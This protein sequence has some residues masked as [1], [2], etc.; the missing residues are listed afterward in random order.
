MTNRITLYDTTLRDG[1][2]TRGVNFSVKDKYKIS[3][4]LN[5][6]G[7]AYIEFGWPGANPVDDEFFASPPILN[8]AKLA[9]FGMTCRSKNKAE[10]DSGLL[11]LAE[12]KA[13]SV[14][15]VGKTWDFHAI[16]AL[17]VSLDE[18]TRMIR[19][20]T[21]FIESQGKEVLFDAEHFFD[22]FRANKEY[23]LSCLREAH[24]AGAAWLV[25]CDTNGGTLPYEIGAIVK[26][27]KKTLPDARLGVHCHDD[28]GNAVADSI[29]ALR[30][31]C[32]MVQ[33]TLNGL[34]ER[35]GN[36]NLV[37]LIPTL[38]DK[39]GYDVGVSDAQ[40]ETLTEMSRSF[41]ML[42]DRDV[43]SNA[44]YV[45]ASAFAHKGGLHASAVAKDP[46]MYEHISPELVGN[47]REVI[48]SDQAGVSN[49]RQQLGELGIEVADDNPALKTLLD[50]VKLRGE[51]GFAYD[52][53]LASFALLSLRTLGRLP[54]FFSVRSCGIEGNGLGDPDL[55][56]DMTSYA[57]LNLQIGKRNFS[58]K[59][60]GVG[61]VNALDGALRRAL[62]GTYPEIEEIRLVDYHV[63]ILDTKAATAATTRVLLESENIKDNSSWVTIGISTNIINASFQALCDSYKYGIM[64]K[65][66]KSVPPTE[67]PLLKGRKLNLAARMVS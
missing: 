53:A 61:P 21:A 40:L 27:V 44:P 45:G 41:A 2:Q 50:E 9:A 55:D 66:K 26:K 29:M 34:G 13:S 51:K 62:V 37:T 38:R 60:E 18:N 11:K 46:R 67:R 3:R 48:I 5:Q 33:G 54:E 6:F 35:C 15:L 17:G 22:G 58:A 20:S 8:N 25:L 65:K 30:A 39:M 4:A 1:A 31:G 23:A 19:D 59:A 64:L 7:V 16:Q 12:S 36:A 24:G 32:E 43:P 52:Y 57:C 42:L 10:K 63:R 28:T 56:S 47:H 14:C 49:L